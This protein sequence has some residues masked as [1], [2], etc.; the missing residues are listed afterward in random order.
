MMFYY[1]NRKETNTE[2]IKTYYGT[3]ANATGVVL[4]KD[5]QGD[6]SKLIDALSAANYAAAKNAPIVLATSSIS[7][8]QKKALLNV[9]GTIA[10]VTQVG[11]G[12]E[13]SILE[14]VAKLLGVSNK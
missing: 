6:T 8:G 5:G 3:G 4:V 7:E 11:E 13:R 1:N 9:N 2:I 12:V 10:S 14:S